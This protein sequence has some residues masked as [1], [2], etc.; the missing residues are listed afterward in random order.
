VCDSSF[1]KRLLRVALPLLLGLL[2]ALVAAQTQ[3]KSGQ[4]TAQGVVK[5]SPLAPY[6]GN[7]YSMFEGKP[8]MLLNL[9]LSGEQFS[10]SLQR[11]RDF[12]FS[13]NGELKR[14]SDE[15]LTYQM[16]DAKLTPD[17]L[18]LT[19]KSP[20]KP[21][22]QRYMMKM[23]GELTAEIKMIEMVMPPGMPKPKPWK[24]TKVH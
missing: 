10:G 19:F 5:K 24:L 4:G 9:N 22:T 7:W 12:A 8:W 17:G 14:V 1:V 20:D 11:S 3:P 23:T 21:E 6:A 15:I 18:L 16:V 13:D 2:S